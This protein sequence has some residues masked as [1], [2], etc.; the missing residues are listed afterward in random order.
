MRI[1]FYGLM[2]AI[3]AL[4]MSAGLAS[5]QQPATGVITGR[6]TDKETQTPIA[7]ATVEAVTATGRAASSAITNENGEYR[8]ANLAGGS[9]SVVVTML[10]YQTHRIESVRV[11][12]GETSLTGA[13]L[14]SEAFQLNPII[15]SASKHTEKALEAPAA[16]S[17]V[18]ER[19]IAE[20]PTT[21][22][23]DHLRNTPGVDIMQTGVQSSN[24]VVRGFNNIFSGA[25]HALT[26]Y[27]IAGIPS[28]R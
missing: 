5:A 8:L 11:I 19:E 7:G 27:R 18:S 16:V 15:V 1:R 2:L 23:V 20:R 4:T 6:I 9:Y 14:T 13:A 10:G 22:P 28:L 17:V 12:S 21:T 24:V 26:D 3:L 25:L